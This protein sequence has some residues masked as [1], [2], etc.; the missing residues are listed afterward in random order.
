MKLSRVEIQSLSSKL[1]VSESKVDT[2]ATCLLEVVSDQEIDK[3]KIT[4]LQ[5]QFSEMKSDQ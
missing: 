1:S 4:D 3:Q 5:T 2:L